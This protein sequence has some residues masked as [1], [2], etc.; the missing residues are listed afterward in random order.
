MSR[1]KMPVVTVL[2]AA[3]VLTAGSWMPGA[4]QPATAAAG[5]PK[6]VYENLPSCR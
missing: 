6:N 5:L 3:I 1:L 2:V 4:D